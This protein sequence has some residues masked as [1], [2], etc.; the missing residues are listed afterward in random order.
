MVSLYGGLMFLLF[1]VLF[2]LT[3]ITFTRTKRTLRDSLLKMS[4]ETQGKFY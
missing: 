1:A 4:V 2:D 3:L